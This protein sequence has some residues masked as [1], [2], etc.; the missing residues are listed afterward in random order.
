[1]K[2]TEERNRGLK[3]DHMLFKDPAYIVEMV[4]NR[5]N[6]YWLG[7]RDNKAMLYYMGGKIL[8]IDQFGYLSFNEKYIEYYNENEHTN[9]PLIGSFNDIEDWLNNES[10]LRTVISYFQ[11]ENHEEK[12]IQ[13]Q[14]MLENNRSSNS[15]WYLVDMEYSVAG[16][17]YG[18]FDM[19]AIPKNRA[20][21]NLHKIML[22]ELKNRTGAFSGSVKKDENDN[23]ISYGSGIAGHINNFYEFLYGREN[24]E[25]ENLK[26]L[27]KEIATI[28]S[29]YR[30]LG[31]SDNL[32][33]IKEDDIDT[34]PQSVECVILCTNIV[35]DKKE[36]A[37]S[38][39]KRFI[40]STEHRASKYCLEKC[41]GDK[42]NEKFNKLNIK[43]SFVNKD[44][45]IDER[46]FETIRR[47]I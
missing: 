4:K 24:R 45:T 3:D 20:E 29:N 25:N 35:T 47:D 31:L 2:G 40:F 32:P 15:D 39:A 37:A 28:L 10:M 19:I 27:G 16:S 23:I 6:E 38:K 42:F 11:S 18:R 44:L 36:S 34:S 43:F 46:S 8:E 21:N 7:I 9:F 12:R 41:W 1:M 13:Q 30:R 14:I 26:R 5:D 22:I 17:K 33:N